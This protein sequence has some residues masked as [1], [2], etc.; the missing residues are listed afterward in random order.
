MAKKR[1]KAGQKSADGKKLNKRVMGFALDPLLIVRL[2]SLAKRSRLTR[3]ALVERLLRDSLD[4]AESFIQ[5]ISDPIGGRAIVEA[6][7]RPEVI[8]CFARAL[9]EEI[10]PKQLKLFTDAIEHMSKK[11]E[12]SK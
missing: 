11:A 3:S 6:F 7:G 1:T 5:F 2:D 4:Q 12:Q 10:D 8:R 9:N